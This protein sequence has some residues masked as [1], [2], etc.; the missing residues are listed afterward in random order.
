MAKPLGYGKVSLEIANADRLDI[1][2][3]L[4]AFEAYMN[5]QLENKIPTWHRLDQV[6]ELVTMSQEQ[7]N[8]DL[9]YMSLDDHV[10]AKRDREGLAKY[11][12]L[13]SNKAAI[14]SFC[15]VDS[16]AAMKEPARKN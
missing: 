11:S 13:V 8:A 16:I 1:S 3:Y 4:G 5:A 12:N 15:D 2:T 14:A 9:M 10:Q 6:T 7:T